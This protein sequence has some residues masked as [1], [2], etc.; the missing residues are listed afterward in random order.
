MKY[1]KAKE[2][3][4]SKQD[5]IATAAASMADNVLELKRWS[6]NRSKSDGATKA[7]RFHVF[8]ADATFPDG[9]KVQ[10]SDIGFV[11]AFAARVI[12]SV[13]ASPVSREVGRRK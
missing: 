9:W 7:S 10:P 5:V 4:D 11:T 12:P 6:R 3:I 2:E 8:P 1:V 13:T